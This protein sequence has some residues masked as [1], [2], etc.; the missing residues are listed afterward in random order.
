MSEHVL[1]GALQVARLADHVEVLFAVQQQTQ[2]APHEVVIVRDHD[3][4]RRQILLGRVDAEAS[5]EM[6]VR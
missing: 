4:D 2:A 5:G 1:G 3:P 6:Q